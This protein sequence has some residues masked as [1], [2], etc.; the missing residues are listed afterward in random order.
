MKMV[1]GCCR[2]ASGAQVGEGSDCRW[3]GQQSGTGK[4][5]SKEKTQVSFLRAP[6]KE[7]ESPEK[8]LDDSTDRTN[9]KDQCTLEKLR[10][11]RPMFGEDRY[12]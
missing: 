7:K 10:E 11:K 1:T 5:R 8:G 2:K 4:W 3:P 12:P 9:G 6:Q